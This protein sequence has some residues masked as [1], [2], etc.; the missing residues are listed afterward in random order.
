[1]TAPLIFRDADPRLQLLEHELAT[2]QRNVRT[3]LAVARTAR[4]A[5]NPN[6]VLEAIYEQLAA[7][8]AVDA[9]SV[10]VCTND[11]L[12]TYRY[13]LMI[14]E[15]VRYELQDTR[16]GGL[17]GYI[18]QH[19][20]PLLFRDLHAEYPPELPHAQAFGNTARQSR[21][22]MGVPLFAGLNAVGVMTV[23][24]YQLG[25][26][27]EAD[28]ELVTALA[29]LA[30]V[31][32][33]NAVLYQQQAELTNSLAER[34]TA[35]QEEL[36]VLSALATGLSRGQPSPELLSE[37]LERVM[38]LLGLDAGAV[39]LHDRKL[40]LRRAAWRAIA[41]PPLGPERLALSGGS[42]EAEALRQG[43]VRQ[44]EIEGRKVCAVPLRAHGRVVGI[45][46]LWGHRT[47][48][49][50]ELTLVG[51]AADQIALGIENG[52][53]L[54]ERD[55]QIAQLEALS[56]IAEASAA[57]RDL[58]SM[59]Q[60]VYA[61]IHDFLRID[62]FVAALYSASTGQL[63]EGVG[64]QVN[65]GLRAVDAP[66]QPHSYLAQLLAGG[67]P[68]LL[69]LPDDGGHLEWWEAG[70]V[71]WLGVPLL[72]RQNTPVGV[73]A[74]Q[75]SQADAFSRGDLQFL[76]NVAHQLT[77]N[78]LNA[79][80]YSEART[81]AAVAERRATNLALLHRISRLVS[82][83]LNPTQV[84][85]IAAEQI[86]AL[87]AIDHCGIMLFSAD[88]GVGEMV[89]EHP[90]LD[91]VG[92]RVTFATDAAMEDEPGSGHPLL[93]ADVAA[94]PR[95][96]PVRQLIESYCIKALLLVPLISRGQA[97]GVISLHMIT[98]V[99]G[100]SDED[101]ELC[102]TLAAQI[103][104]ALE[105]ARLHHLTV[106][107]VEQE[108]EIA[109]SIQANL[110]PR[111]LPTI[112]GVEL[113]GKCVP[114]LETGGDFYDVLPLGDGR[115]GFSIG[116]V[117]GKSLA[118]AMVMA[119]A[120][121]V[122]RSEALDHAAP[123]V[124]MAETNALVRQDIPPSTFVALCYAVYDARRREFTL[125]N[126]GQM[127]PLLRHADGTVEWLPVPGNLPL[128]IVADLVYEATT[129]AV[130]PGDTVLFLTDGLVEAF[131]PTGEMF[132]FERVRALLQDCGA[133]PASEV[134]ATLLD[135]VC[136]WQGHENR[137]DDMTVI[138]AQIGADAA[139]LPA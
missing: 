79:Q 105:N 28:L 90:A 18:L 73:I 133:Q 102:R 119:V 71:V 4:G 97:F 50:D 3:L 80:L 26:Y 128:G 100:F 10:V 62:G 117:S 130:A 44:A 31:A 101:F 49:D 111:T 34:V 108:L 104:A 7:L 113:A 95:L 15:G 87:F 5:T 138:V 121:S 134:V 8:L 103:T 99:R 124:V 41:E 22:W 64:W 70:A 122:V 83:S 74:I 65:A 42:V 132:G 98:A 47:L 37:A 66:V 52:R 118:A 67:Q 81:S 126:A 21:A 48:A 89:A 75:S 120:R 30:A 40:S 94:D 14:D 72:D 88:G 135:T 131:S 13:M 137:H 29:D 1:M 55:R 115:F 78:V 16:T 38:W 57:T 116:D 129:I 32:I 60:E 11:Q 85:Q 112:P 136:A 9:F 20:R 110:F 36:A 45:M 84:L 56:A 58:R 96:R 107:R 59:L 6:V 68:V 77:L 76:A 82:A 69:R 27:T 23:Q 33:E 127:T 123:D 92:L 12:D 24:S 2:E 39:W 106:T 54:L 93:I 61:A 25:V 43:Q 109:R 51:A 46:T 139:A 125:A 17:T 35:R 91:T 53:L 86:T 114:A 19:Q 63:H